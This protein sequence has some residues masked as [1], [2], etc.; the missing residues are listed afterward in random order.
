MANFFLN[1]KLLMLSIEYLR[2]FRIGEYAIFDFAASFLAAL[3]LAPLLT[4]LFKKLNINIPFKSWMYFVLPLGIIVHLL[5]G[6]I[7]PMTRDF[8]DLNGHYFLKFIMIAL[9]ILGLKG[10]SRIKKS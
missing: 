2:Q 1:K 3:I 7:T 10:I 8:L 4:T 6:S 9:L 5:F